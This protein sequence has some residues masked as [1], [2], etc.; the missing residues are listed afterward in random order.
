MRLLPRL[1]LAVSAAL[2]PAVASAQTTLTF[3]ASQPNAFNNGSYLV[4]PFDGTLATPPG[5]STS[6]TIFCVDILNT[7]GYGDT[8]GVNVT[9][10]ADGSDLS[11]TRHPGSLTQYREAAWISSYFS[12]VPQTYWGSMQYAMW[13]L[14]N[15]GS[16]PTDANS[17]TII[18]LANYA[19]SQN[20]Q[21]FSIG[22]YTYAA[23]DY[24][25]YSVFTDVRAAGHA[26]DAFEQE[27]I[28]GTQL[29]STATPEPAT[30][31]LTAGGLCIVYGLVR[32]RRLTA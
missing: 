16:A 27:F 12:L 23:F 21:S 4:G 15:P 22:S 25:K 14:L 9:S 3:G 19:A 6:L 18:S 17:P 28:S 10:L 8:F 11:N 24:S 31:V 7:V 1:V 29:P 26:D 5:Q 13:G 30:F 20:F 2:V 32:R